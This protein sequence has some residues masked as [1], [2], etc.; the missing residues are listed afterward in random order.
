MDECEK[1]RVESDPVCTRRCARAIES[2]PHHRVATVRQVDPD[3]MRSTRFQGKGEYGP[4]SV[5]LDDSVSRDRWIA[6]RTHGPLHPFT[7]PAD[8]RIDHTLRRLRRPLHDEPGRPICLHAAALGS[9]HLSGTIGITKF[10][11]FRRPEPMVSIYVILVQGKTVSGTDRP[12]P[13]F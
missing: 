9:M 5:P 12:G 3:L 2:V 10:I 8:R 4:S 7:S 1:R 6:V 11:Y 13:L